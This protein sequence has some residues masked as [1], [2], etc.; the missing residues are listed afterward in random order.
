MKTYKMEIRVSSIQEDMDMYES[1]VNSSK[2]IEAI[3]IYREY[4]GRKRK[5]HS[6]EMKMV[7]N[8][9]KADV[10]E[11]EIRDLFL[12]FEGFQLL[13][14]LPR[15][16]KL[17]MYGIIV[18]KIP[19]NFRLR[20]PNLRELEIRKCD[21]KL[22][23]IFDRLDENVLQ[24]L[25]LFHHEPSQSKYF[26]KQ[27]SIVDLTTDE[28]GLELLDLQ[29]MKLKKV[30]V[31]QC[32]HNLDGLEGQDEIVEMKLSI[33]FD[34]DYEDYYYYDDDKVLNFAEFKS[35]EVLE[36][37]NDTGYDSTVTLSSLEKL[38]NLKK[39][40]VHELTNIKSAS[41]QELSFDCFFSMQ[42][43]VQTAIN[44]PNLRVL[45]ANN[46]D[47]DLIFL[48]LPRLECLSCCV[49]K[50]DGYAIHQHLKHLRIYSNSMD[51]L[52][53]IVNRC[54]VL[55]SLSAS[56]N[57][58]EA[59]IENLLVSKP[60]LKSLYLA[61]FDSKMLGTIKKFGG[62]LEVFQFIS[63][64][65]KFTLEILKTELKDV[66]DEFEKQEKGGYPFR[67]AFIVKKAGAVANFKFD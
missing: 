48:H 28:N 33:I 47:I 55:E 9:F 30:D 24:K 22:L 46:I 54:E 31:E 5:F 23:E 19:Q 66:F 20:L 11:L 65:E 17:R 52:L 67:R 2:K 63:Y 50:N 41:L 10:K 43:L 21:E 62:N 1:I 13:I 16:E 60:G 44:C 40:K 18:G 27:R 53:S 38:P 8:N 56:S 26:G 3:S 58:T 61:N 51:S 35:L 57:F 49:S 42:I 45:D 29:Q 6:K 59:S 34:F 7:L 37:S 12:T 25:T 15:V 32:Q 39:L 14:T 36:L 64:E 4:C